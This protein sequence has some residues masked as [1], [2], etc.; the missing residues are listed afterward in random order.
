LARDAAGRFDLDLEK[1]F[2]RVNR[3]K[4]MAAV[5][6]RRATP[7]QQQPGA[8]CGAARPVHPRA[9]GE[10]VF[11]GN[12]YTC[13]SHCAIFLA[14][15]SRYGA[16]PQVWC[17]HDSRM[18]SWAEER[19]IAL[20]HIQ[21]DRPMQNCDVQSFHGERNECP[22]ANWLR[23]SNKARTT[24]ESCRQEYNCERPHRPLAY[25]TPGE[26][27]QIARYVVIPKPNL[28]RESLVMTG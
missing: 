6:R 20:V 15:S 21:P 9:L 22:P 1:S 17:S 4:L 26:F 25:R 18:L 23:A 12:V 7:L 27:R 2:D 14:H 5:A 3:D 19:K 16:V 8:G 11:Q 10:N 28:K 24:L 13:Y